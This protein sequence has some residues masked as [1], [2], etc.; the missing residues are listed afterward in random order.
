ML[1]LRNGRPVIR[2]ITTWETVPADADGDLATGT[3]PRFV[4]RPGFVDVALDTLGVVQ[5][6]YIAP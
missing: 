5:A 1:P 3:G 2:P 6:F 4:T